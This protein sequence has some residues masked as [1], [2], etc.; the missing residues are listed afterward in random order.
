M[1]K[2]E[3]AHDL[4][5][6]LGVVARCSRARHL[7]SSPEASHRDRKSADWAAADAEAA[8]AVDRSNSPVKADPHPDWAAM[9][10]AAETKA[11]QARKDWA[12][13]LAP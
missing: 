12:V 6:S 1:R 13:G 4:D 5:H 9:V 3:K 7:P 8:Q 11:P 2:V 10:A